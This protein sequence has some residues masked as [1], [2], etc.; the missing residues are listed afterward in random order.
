MCSKGAKTFTL[1]SLEHHRNAP[2]EHAGPREGAS[3]FKEKK[4]AKLM[5][6][7]GL[8]WSTIPLTD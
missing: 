7:A 2:C 4:T 1:G 6:R 5:V 3:M 8:C